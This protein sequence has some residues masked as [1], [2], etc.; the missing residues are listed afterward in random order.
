MNILNIQTDN[1][2]SLKSKFE[3]VLLKSNVRFYSEGL[4]CIF[5]EYGLKNMIEFI[6]KSNCNYNKLLKRVKVWPKTIIEDKLKNH[7]EIYAF[8]NYKD[9]LEKI[10]RGLI[11]AHIINESTRKTL[12]SDINK[13]I[14][15]QMSCIK[16]SLILLKNLKK[17]NLNTDSL[18]NL[19]FISSYQGFIY[20][21]DHFL[22]PENLVEDDELNL[23]FWP[24]YEVQ[25]ADTKF[26][27]L[28]Y[29]EIDNKLVRF[30]FGK[31]KLDIDVHLLE[32]LNELK[33]HFEIEIKWAGLQFERKIKSN[34]IEIN[35]IH[36]RF[37]KLEYLYRTLKSKQD[38][39]NDDLEN[40]N[41][42]KLLETFVLPEE[43]IF[44]KID[45]MLA[46]NKTVFFL[47]ESGCG[48]TT[49][50]RQYAPYKKTKEEICSIVFI[51]SG[52][53]QD[54]LYE[55]KE[56]FFKFSDDIFE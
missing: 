17:E 6:E 9:L 40:E 41:N 48:K 52:T 37:A 10:P 29:D 44:Q 19:K 34:Q 13:A 51:H 15:V 56:R 8:I 23:I 14:N 31:D 12:Q 3:K 11:S 24:S 1:D 22:S 26:D 50:A 47:G 46:S 16:I 45:S 35:K 39:K 53:I 43:N 49:L 5:P 20:K 54:N 28:R 30:Y 18:P 2:E 55:L 25:E 7:K 36:D 32:Q 42:W 27:M 38:S 4:R 33:S 21:G